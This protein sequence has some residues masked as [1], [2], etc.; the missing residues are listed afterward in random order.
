VDSAKNNCDVA[1]KL[2]SRGYRDSVKTVTVSD[3]LEVSVRTHR[4][5]CLGGLVF[6]MNK[7]VPGLK[8]PGRESDH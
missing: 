4:S 1:A 3:Q 5:I 6:G 7:C 2:L 8:L